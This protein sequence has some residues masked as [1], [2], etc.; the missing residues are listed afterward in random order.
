MNLSDMAD[1]N[2]MAPGDLLLL[3]TFG[4]GASWS[5]LLLEH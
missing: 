4:F 1:E 3:F 5:C 2:A